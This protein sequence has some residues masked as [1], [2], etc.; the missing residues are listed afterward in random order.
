MRKL[1]LGILGASWWT[2]VTCPGFTMA[3]NAEVTWIASRTGDRAREAAAKHGIARWSTDY[4]EV[5]AAADVDAVF[6]AVPNHLHHEMAMAALANGKHVLQEKPMALSLELAVAQAAEAKKRGLQHMVD[7]ELRLADGFCDFAPIIADRIGPL[8]KATL[9]VTLKSG[10]W[11]GWRADP[12]L[13]GG[14]LFEMAIHQLDLAHWLFGRDPIAVWATGTDVPGNDFTAIIDF[15]GGDTALIDFC[16][17]SV[18]FHERVECSGE[19][20]VASLDL[21]MPFGGGFRTITN[22]DGIERAPVDMSAQGPLT[23]RRVLEGFADAVLTGAPLP[24]PTSDG[25]WAICLAEGT[26]RSMRSGEWV[27]LNLQG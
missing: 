7:L 19:R 22:A 5:L 13:T 15:G 2:D 14:A 11:G 26:R 21:V 12:T 17:R 24:I 20:G 1:R 9:R 3:K 23:F 25:V 6:I 27:S 16:W 4:G 10:A 8:R 18:G